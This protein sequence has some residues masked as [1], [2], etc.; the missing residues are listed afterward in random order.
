MARFTTRQTER[1]PIQLGL[2]GIMD[3]P[4]GASAPASRLDPLH[5][6]TIRRRPSRRTSPSADSACLTSGRRTTTDSHGHQSTITCRPSPSTLWSFR[7]PTLTGFMSEL[8][9]VSFPVLMAERRGRQGW[10]IPMS[11]SWNFSG[12]APSSLLLPMAGACSP[13]AG[14]AAGSSCRLSTGWRIV[15]HQASID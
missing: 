14:S 4:E 7:H 6:R 11:L 1:R 3:C 2:R 5:Q 10:E 13:S 15:L 12:W 9:L 8:R